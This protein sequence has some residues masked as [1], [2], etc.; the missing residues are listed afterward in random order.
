MFYHEIFLIF[1]TLLFFT[2]Y[3]VLDILLQDGEI[4]NAL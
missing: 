2:A 3:I 4:C 1:F